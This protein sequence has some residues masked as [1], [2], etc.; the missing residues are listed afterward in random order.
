MPDAAMALAAQALLAHQSRPAYGPVGT[1][2]DGLEVLPGR[3]RL[4]GNSFL[5]RT[6][7]G[8]GFHYSR[9][10]GLTVERP[11]QFD[12]G[13]E[14]LWRDGSVYAAIAAINGLRPVH[15]SAIAWNGGVY[16]FTGPSGAGKSTL[17][18]ALG[19]LG[20][21]LF[22]DDTLILDLSDP[23]TVMALPGHKR[24]KLTPEALRLTAARGQERVAPDIDKH[25][26]EPPA[27]VVAEP[28]P[29]KALF[30]LSF[31]PQAAI[32]PAH[33]GLRV[34]LLNDDHYTQELYWATRNHDRAALFAEMARIAAQVG[35]ATLVRPHDIGAVAESARVVADHIRQGAKE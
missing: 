6:E 35:I 9:G 16:A 30:T 31:G 34:A 15:A 24:L 27:G 1:Q 22:C 19:R 2:L 18:T 28:L 20:F 11:E 23:N 14:Q 5:L 17:V 7:S 4:I 12:P 13:E 26:A 29:L 32:V 21:P 10:Q 3:H 33:G 25:F 8:F